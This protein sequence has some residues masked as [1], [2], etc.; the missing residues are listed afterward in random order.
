MPLSSAQRRALAA[1]ANSLKATVTVS[2]GALG[3]AVVSHVRTA[4]GSRPLV[5]VRIHADDAATCDAAAAELAARVPCELV[6][7]VGRVALLYRAP[8][9]D[10]SGDA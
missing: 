4:L 10:T 9:P 8:G 2:A 1:E 6:Q 5:K 3:D 7:R